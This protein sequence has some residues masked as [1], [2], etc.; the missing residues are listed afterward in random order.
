MSNLEIPW[1]I[2]E[3]TLIKHTLLKNY[4]DPWM[5][6]FFAVQRGEGKPQKVIYV[7]G[8]CGPGIYYTDNTKTDKCCG[9]PLIVAEVANKYLNEDP[10]RAVIMH[11]IDKNGVCTEILTQSLTEMNMFKQEWKVHNAEFDDK[12]HEVLDTIDQSDLRYQPMFFFIDPFGY[13]GFPMSTLHKIMTYPR[14]E[15]FVNFMVYDIVRFCEEQPFGENMSALFGSNEFRNV[16]NCRSPHEKYV[17]FVNLYVKS[18]TSI[19]ARYVMPFRINTPDQGTRPRYYLIHASKHIRALRVMKDNMAKISQAPYRFEAIGL[20]S[21]QMSL[22][23]DP[24]RETLRERI[25]HFCAEPCAEGIRYEV[26]EEWAYVNTNGTSRTIKE[27]LLELE[28]QKRI[29]IERQARQRK[30]TVTTG[31]IIR[32]YGG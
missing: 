22:F 4:I 26:L 6:I 31:A 21:E 27:A 3:H 25:G 19:G 28:M 11:C 13:K 23:E 24:E 12:I 8:F 1:V 14:A 18:L 16:S 2:D 10:T 5:A 17:F 9:S 15:F 30:N 20:I 32:T 7:D 29:S